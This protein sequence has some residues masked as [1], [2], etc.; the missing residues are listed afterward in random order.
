MKPLRYSALKHMALSP[1]HFKAA[2]GQPD[3]APPKNAA[4]L[5]G[6]A[7]HKMILTAGQEIVVFTGKTRRGKV[8]DAFKAEHAG[9]LILNEREHAQAQRMA[10]AVKR[11]PRAQALLTAAP[12]REET[13]RW[14]LA[15]RDCQGTP[16]AWGT[17]VLLD[18]KTT[19][20]A[21]PDRFA[22]E[23]RRMGYHGQLDWYAEGIRTLNPGDVPRKPYIIA[24]ENSGVPAVTVFELTEE[25]LA[26]GRAMWSAWFE[27][28]CVCVDS[29]HWP[30]YSECIEKL[31]VPAEE[32]LGFD[33]P[34]G[35]ITVDSDDGAD[36]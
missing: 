25:L 14:Q 18:V 10:D 28:Y 27:R 35:E 15:G 26:S 17:D 6:S 29:N 12:H 22:W 13:L 4:M 34:D 19:K 21:H 24:V 1:M 30:A 3:N 9:K 32:D 23:A 5:V 8:W 31:D 11:D 33:I 16:D 36:E 7:A 2:E 20:T